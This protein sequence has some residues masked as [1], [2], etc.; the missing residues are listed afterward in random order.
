MVTVAE[1]GKVQGGQIGLP[2]DDAVSLVG[3][4]QPFLERKPLAAKPE[5][6]ANEQEEHMRKTWLYTAVLVL[7]AASFA[8]AAPPPGSAKAGKVVF[9]QHCKACHGPNGEGNPAIAKM[10]HVKMLPLGS[11][12]VQ[13]KSDAQ[14]KKDITEGIGKMAGVKG[15]SGKQVNDV[16]AFIRELGKT[17]KK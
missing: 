6:S 11:K 13:A 16:V 2:L 12:E 1:V 3:R 7:G 5:V 15:L 17:K 10:M 4:I 14:L 9:D 8:W